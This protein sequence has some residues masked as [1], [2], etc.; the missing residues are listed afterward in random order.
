M[1]A[2]MLPTAAFAQLKMDGKGK[3]SVGAEYAPTFSPTQVGSGRADTLSVLKVFGPYGSYCGGG[4]VAFGDWDYQG[5]AK[6]S[7]G[8]YG[9][10]NTDRLHLYG[11]KGFVVSTG[12]SKPTIEYSYRSG[13]SVIVNA[14]LKAYSFLVLEKD[15]DTPSIQLS[16]GK[17]AAADMLPSLDGISAVACPVVDTD[18]EQTALATAIDDVAETAQGDVQ[19]V[20]YGFDIESVEAAMPEL[21]LTDA[22][23]RKYVDYMSFIP[24]LVDRINRLQARVDELEGAQDEVGRVMRAPTAGA[25]MA[26]TGRTEL[27]QNSPNPASAV[28]GIR[29]ALADDVA[30]AQIKVY[31]LQGLEKL[32]FDLATGDGAGSVSIEASTLPAGMYLYS[33]I[34]DGRLIDT[35]RMIITK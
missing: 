11:W 25:E 30:T 34:A 16:Q 19:Q 2:V 1:A 5:N 23:G 22:G 15:D 14:P 29:Y 10:T 33:L 28:T 27:F 12:A 7:V 13:A 6:V 21:V 4:Q 8:E 9:N 20:R 18:V 31:D 32:S 17:A 26:V 3:M 35:K 24:L